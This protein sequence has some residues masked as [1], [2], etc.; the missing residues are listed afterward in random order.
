MLTINEEHAKEKHIHAIISR[1][2]EECKADQCICKTYEPEYDKKFTQRGGSMR[3]STRGLGISSRTFSLP[4]AGSINDLKKLP[5]KITYK[6]K[7]DIF[8]A[9][10]AK[11]VD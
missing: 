6:T 1:H 10:F 11:K 9:E 2:M 7:I 4:A 8:K 5:Y 3:M